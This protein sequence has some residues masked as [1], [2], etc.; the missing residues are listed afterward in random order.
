M[1]RTDDGFHFNGFRSPNGT[2]VPDEFF[3][4][5]MTQLTEG[6]LRVLLY[7]IRRTFGW[8]KQ[9]DNISLKQMIDGIKAH[10]GR[11][12]DR[13][14]G[15]VRSAAVRA[16]KGLE[17]KGVILAVRNRSAEKGDEPTTYTLRF[18]E[19][20][21]FSKETG[22]SSLK[23]LGGVL[24]RNPQTTIEQQTDIQGSSHSN[25]SP[26]VDKSSGAGDNLGIGKR[27]RRTAYLDLV[28]E[29]IS[30]QLHDSEHVAP[31]ISRARHLQASSGLSEQAFVVAIYE[32]RAITLERGDIQKRSTNG[33][34]NKAPYFFA[35]LEDVL[36]LKDS[37]EVRER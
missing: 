7:I 29:E 3:D 37:S 13:G 8:K 19:A 33:H 32:A 20:P 26:T 24:Q 27:Q 18:L 23:E 17:E 30:K 9:S 4:E 15:V 10:D 31:N 25:E 28:I 21:V 11:V 22:G 1:S 6:E 12:I 16:I 14:A 5:L 35:V 36:G 34:R 2:I